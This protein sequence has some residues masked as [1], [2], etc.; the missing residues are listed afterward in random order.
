MPV[1]TMPVRSARQRAVSYSTAIASR[2]SSAATAGYP[3]PQNNK[4]PA[5]LVE[6]INQSHYLCALF[7][8][9]QL[10]WLKRLPTSPSFLILVT[11]SPVS[12]P[13]MTI[14]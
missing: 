8:Q 2:A 11:V 10:R 6:H 3:A 7:E 14:K 4:F 1:L 5:L 12:V 13:S 9:A